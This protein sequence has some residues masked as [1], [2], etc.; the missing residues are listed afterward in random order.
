MGKLFEL[1]AAEK[2]LSSASDKLIEE[3]KAKFQKAD[4][5]FK[6]HLKTLKML[7]DNP[8]N[9]AIESAARDAKPVTTNVI[10]TLQYTLDHWAKAEDCIFQKNCT[11]QEATADLEFRGQVIRGGVPVDELMGL[12]NRLKTIRGML[13]EVPTLDASREWEPDS[14]K[15]VGFWRTQNE[16]FTTKTE[17]V[18]TPVLLAP[19]TDKHPAQVKESNRDVVIGQFTQRLFSGAA[20]TV[21]KSEAIKAV[22]D[23]IVECR[24]ARNRANT[25]DAQTGTIGGTIMGLILE[26]IKRVE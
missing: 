22:D 11:N 10:D 21:G 15:G 14:Q 9:T 8:E 20:T 23:L 4:S 25:V 19:A 7:A 17:K 24:K 26:Q 13:Q 5:F 3:T 18:M 12:E 1:L 6:G 16:E 2:T